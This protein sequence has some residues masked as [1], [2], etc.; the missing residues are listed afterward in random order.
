MERI[1]RPYATGVGKL[2]R[3]GVA[4]AAG[5]KKVALELLTKAERDFEAAGMKTLV[6]VARCRRAKLCGSESLY[7]ETIASMIELKIQNPF[8]MLTMFAPGFESSSSVGWLT[9]QREAIGL[10]DRDCHERAALE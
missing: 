2:V 8:A 7:N 10:A 6:A 4:A 1:K 9:A 3:A 5:R